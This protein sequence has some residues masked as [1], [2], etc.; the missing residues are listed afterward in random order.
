MHHSPFRGDYERILLPDDLAFRDLL[1]R[2]QPLALP[3]IDVLHL[4]SP[5]PS[6]NVK[7]LNNL[8]AYGF[9]QNATAFG[10]PGDFWGYV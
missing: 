6:L 5:R 2:E 3:S 4:N 1:L 10:D 7:I 9:V 8:R